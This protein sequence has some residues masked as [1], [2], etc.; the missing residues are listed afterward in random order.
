MKFSIEPYNKL[1]DD[2]DRLYSIAVDEVVI[3]CPF[4]HQIDHDQFIGMDD[5]GIL[6]TVAARDNDD[7]VGVHVSIITND[8]FYKDKKTSFVSDY[9]LLKKYRGG[10]AGLKMFQFIEDD[11]IKRNIDRSF[12]S[13]KIHISNEK[14]FD[15]LGYN[16][17]EANYEKYYI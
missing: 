12:M 2:I 8:V 10:G 5:A 3:G 17:I 14:L 9:F 16:H 4:K 13:R 15:A 1:I 7:L 11:N 6:R